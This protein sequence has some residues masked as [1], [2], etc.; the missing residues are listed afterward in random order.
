MAAIISAD[1]FSFNGLPIDGRATLAD[2]AKRERERTPFG[3]RIYEARKH[4]GLT[5]TQLAN[6]C[7]L[8][9]STLGELEVKGDSSMRTVQIAEACG[10]RAQWLADG[11]GPMVDV[12][13]LPPEVEQLAAEMIALPQKQRDWVLMTLRE[14]VKLAKETVAPSDHRGEAVTHSSS[15]KRRVA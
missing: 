5:Q 8:A 7:G 4:A 13:R 2:V 10:V 1:R 12:R 9:Q 14:A 3:Q 15:A 11:S 6:A